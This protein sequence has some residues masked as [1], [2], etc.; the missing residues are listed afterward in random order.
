MNTDQYTLPLDEVK[1]E[2]LKNA[3]K[4]FPFM[5]LPEEFTADDVRELLPSPV[6]PNW[7]G[8]L[9]AKLRNTGAVVKCGWAK[10]T[11]PERNGAEI[12]AWR[13]A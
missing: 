10:T 7:M 12:R 3:E 9:L 11:R 13:R 6:E 5:I 8:C 4:K 1:N 2:W